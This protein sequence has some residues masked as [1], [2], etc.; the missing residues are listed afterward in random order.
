MPKLTPCVILLFVAAWPSCGIV[1]AQPTLVLSSGTVAAG[2][3]ISLNLTL[4]SPSGSEPAGLQWTFSYPASSLVAFNVEAA[5][6]LVSA[7]KTISCAGDASAYICLAT[8]LN[9]NTIANGIVA[10]VTVTLAATGTLTAIGLTNTLGASPDGGQLF[11]SATAGMI[12]IAPSQLPPVPISSNPAAGSGGSTFAF[13]FND[14]RGWQDLGVVTILFNNTLDG[15]HACYLVYS[16]PSNVLYLLD[17]AGLTLLP[18][19]ASVGSV[20]NSQC[21]VSWGKAAASGTANILRLTLT[22]GF[23]QSFAGNKVIYMA[24]GNTAGNNSGWQPLGVWQVPA[25]SQPTTTTVVGMSPAR[26]NGIGQATFTFTF[27]DQDLGVA[28]ILL[29][30]VLDGRHACYLAY[31]APSMCCI[32]S[33]ITGTPCRPASL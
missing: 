3:T 26:E 33:M 8:G 14:P 21:A 1:F 20:S 15:R 13:V 6:A 31:A 10:T 2:G 28:N 4:T 9:A 23:N 27:S 11:I 16:Q 22:V 25:A 29:N 12:G 5:S 18:L 30:T 19:L 7:N 32:W 17:D 24:A